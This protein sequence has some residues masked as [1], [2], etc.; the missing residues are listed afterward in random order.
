MEV[1]YKKALLKCAM[2]LDQ[3]I[4]E[5]VVRDFVKQTSN[6]FDDMAADI[7]L[8]IIRESI[9]AELAKP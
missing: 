5:I 4:L 3:D 2:I 6:P 9:A 1:N 7:A 8:K